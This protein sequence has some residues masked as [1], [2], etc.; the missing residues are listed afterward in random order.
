MG[1]P[2]KPHFR[3][4]HDPKG[5]SLLELVIA[6]AI[7]GILSAV[8][9]PNFSKI[10]HRAKEAALKTLVYTVQMAVESYY[11]SNGIYPAGQELPLIKLSEILKTSGDLNSPPKNPYTGKTY[12]ASD[13]SGRITYSFNAASEQYT[14]LGYGYKN[15][16]EIIR[17]ENL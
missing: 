9:F 15:Q 11:L 1:H 10:Q 8:I 16:E 7:I 3:N 2:R 13:P 12:S 5:F 14:L 4:A 6:V 17:V